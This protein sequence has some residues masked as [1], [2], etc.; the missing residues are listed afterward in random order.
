MTTNTTAQPAGTS[1]STSA[2]WATVVLTYGVRCANLTVWQGGNRV[3]GWENTYGDIAEAEAERDR[4][5]AVFEAHLCESGIARHRHALIAERDRLSRLRS[6]TS[7]VG[8]ID[9]ELDG[10]QDLTTRANTPAFI[11][12]QRT[13]H[14]A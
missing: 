4:T 7:R 10:L 6:I 13:R 2:G 9:D 8:Q 11:A 5:V 3:D 14:A 12:D 1:L